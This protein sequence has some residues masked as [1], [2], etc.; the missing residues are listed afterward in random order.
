MVVDFN[1]VNSE[2]AGWSTDVRPEFGTNGTDA[3]IYEIHVRDMTIDPDSNVTKEKRGTFAGLAEKGT[4]YT[5]GD[6]TVS[7]GLDHIKELGVTHVQILPFYDYNSVE[8]RN[9]STDM[10]MEVEGSNYNWG[11]DPLN[12]NALEGSYSTNPYDGLNRIKEFKEMVMAMH[13][14][15]INIIMDVVYNHTAKT[16]DSNFQLLVPEYYHRRKAGGELYN[17]SGCGNEMA[18]DRSMVNKFVVDSAK[19]WV[20]EYHLGGISSN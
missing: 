14:Y 10:S 6:V 3:S 5:K 1:K 16:N 17:G 7:T 19:F 8:E 2:I 9:V 4:S 12:Y 15:G 18:S 11:Y 20:E 13:S